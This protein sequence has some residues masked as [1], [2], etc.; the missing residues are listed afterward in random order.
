MY[1]RIIILNFTDFIYEF[2][3]IIKIYINYF[4]FKNLYS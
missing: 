3:M 4:V 2:E 1:E